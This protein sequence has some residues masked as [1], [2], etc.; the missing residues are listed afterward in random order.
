MTGSYHQSSL[1]PRCPW[2][3]SNIDQ[4]FSVLSKITGGKEVE[5]IIKLKAYFTFKTLLY[6]SPLIYSVVV[7]LI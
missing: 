7:Y 5:H 3:Y 6:S 4:F 2:F 1:L